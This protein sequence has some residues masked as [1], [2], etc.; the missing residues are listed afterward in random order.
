MTVP[1]NT[2]QPPQPSGIGVPTSP[3]YLVNPAHESIH[4]PL[5]TCN[6]TSALESNP[7]ALAIDGQSSYI[8]LI[9]V[10][11]GRPYFALASSADCGKLFCNHWHCA[12]CVATVGGR[13]GIGVNV[14]GIGVNVGGTSVGVGGI[15]VNVGGIGVNVGGTGVGVHTAVGGG[16]GVKVGKRLVVEE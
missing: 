14:G 15:G 13:V 7:N 11:L 6:S 16:S 8:N 1:L 10:L 4:P 5:G 3:I 9:V 12:S 2:R